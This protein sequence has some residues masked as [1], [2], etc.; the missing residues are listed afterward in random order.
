[1]NLIKR[2]SLFQF[3]QKKCDQFHIDKS[4]GLIHSK[5]C[6][7]L[8]DLMIGKDKTLTDDEKIVA[9]YSAAL[10][11]L[12]DKKYVQIFESITEIREWLNTILRQE[13]VEAILSIIQTM[14]YSFLDQ[15]R[16]ENGT[17]WYPDHGK[18]N[19]SY[20]LARNADLLEGYEV[21]RCYLYTKNI[22]PEWNEDQVWER[23]KNFFE[24]RVFKYLSDGWLTDPYAIELAPF[25]EEKARNCFITL[26]WEYK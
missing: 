6:M 17:H 23:V 15:R 13:I 16:Y 12:C 14:S 10:H 22:Y 4:H 20:H 24:R 5:R 7:S 19:K 8:V 26:N 18:W 1:M 2:D 3:I 9:I 21:G 11:N 25:L